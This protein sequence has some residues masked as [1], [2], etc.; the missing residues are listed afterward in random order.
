MQAKYLSHVLNLFYPDACAGCSTILLLGENILCTVC[1]H[2]LPLTLHFVQKENDAFQKFYGRIP[3]EFVAALLYFHKQGIVQQLI[4][5]LKYRGHQ[6][7]GDFVGDWFSAELLQCKI[8]PT[9]DCVIPV[10]LHKKRLRERGYN[11]VERFAKSIARNLSIEYNDKLLQRNVYLKTQ[12]SKNLLNRAAV[13]ENIFGVTDD[14]SQMGKHFLVVDDVL[15]TGA[16]L[17]A[18]CRELLRIPDLKVSIACMAMT[19]S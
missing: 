6:E 18:C 11:Q 5:H 3:V 15:T 13:T 17:E 12:A 2:N 1:R 10:P 7:I 19:Q 4:H 14:N 16:T 9:F 8:A